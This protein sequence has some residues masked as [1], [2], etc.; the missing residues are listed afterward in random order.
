MNSIDTQFDDRLKALGTLKWL[1]WTGKNFYKLP[2]S[3]KLIIVGESH[4]DNWIGS[5]NE[6]E[7]EQFTRWYI[8]D[9]AI[10]NPEKESKIIRNSERVVFNK[11]PTKQE[12]LNFWESICYF[13]FIQRPMKTKSD[14]PIPEDYVI[15]WN[16]FFKVIKI[17]EPDYVL[18]CGVSASNHIF[19]FNESIKRENFTSNGIEKLEKIGSTFPRKSIV[20]SPN[21]YE[22]KMLFIKH[23]SKHFPWS[24][25]SPLIKNEFKNY[26]E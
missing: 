3:K 2:K 24:K 13:N 5:D 26:T 14:R 1:P 18:F 8:R 25:W 11:N 20:L 15:G 23:P 4:Y 7:D 19:L 12:S 22:S 10:D 16:T 21:K 6:V 17:I 9:H